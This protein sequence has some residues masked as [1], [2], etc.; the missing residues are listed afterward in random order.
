M[1]REDPQGESQG[2]GMET[3]SL[4]WCLKDIQVAKCTGVPHLPAALILFPTFSHD[5]FS[6][7][8]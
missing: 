1:L 6:S 8:R 7:P 5:P 2:F 4:W 3:M